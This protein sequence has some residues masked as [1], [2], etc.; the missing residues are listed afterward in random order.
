LEQ[1]L[2][3]HSS[4]IGIR[5]YRVDRHKLRRE[6]TMIETAYGPV[7]A[8]I[9]TLPNG[10]ARITVEDDDARSAAKKAGVS[11]DQ[12]RRDAETKYSSA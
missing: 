4:A 9:V 12:V 2:F 3:E 11:A 6:S 7:Q 1:I 5:R 8:K 10:Q